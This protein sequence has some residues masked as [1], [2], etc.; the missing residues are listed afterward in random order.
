MF[1]LTLLL[2]FTASVTAIKNTKNSACTNACGGAALTGQQ[3][4]NCDDDAFNTT[5][6]GR[7]MKSCLECESTSTM[8][9]SSSTTDSDQY[10][11]LFNMKYTLQVCI[12]ELST[13]VPHFTSCTPQ[14]G[15][16]KTV[17]QTTWSP[18]QDKVP[19]YDYCN[20]D[21][22]SFPQNSD[23][24]ATCLRT[25]T[26]YQVLANFMNTMKG[27]CD[28]KPDLPQGQTLSMPRALFDMTNPDGSSP[29]PAVTSSS[30]SSASSSST[31]SS[32]TPL[33]A[34]Q[35]A[36]STAPSTTTTSASAPA[37]TTQAAYR[38]PTASSAGSSG[39]STGAVAGI[40]VAA[41]IGGISVFAAALAFFWRRRR[42]QHERQL[43]SSSSPLQEHYSNE[44]A[45]SPKEPG[46]PPQQLFSEQRHEADDGQ[47]PAELPGTQFHGF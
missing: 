46:S 31:T 27:A 38:L 19:L 44:K 20:L 16:I 11:L 17:L 9:N 8:T 12:F 37:G 2:L 47:P 35:S 4:L 41:A 3:E 32:Q 7:K 5:D 10:W 6:K 36:N 45:A 1:F 21:G 15:K 43:S 33:A 42:H 29:A 18:G 28:N 14:C 34:V 25:L 22:G 24:C 40:G 13:E 39:L 30:A 23:A 26:G